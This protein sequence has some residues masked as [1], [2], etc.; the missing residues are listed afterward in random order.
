MNNDIA[1]I[2]N[3]GTEE[4]FFRP[5]GKGFLK[6]LG[7]LGGIYNGLSFGVGLG[8]NVI[9]ELIEDQTN[10][11][12]GNRFGADVIVGTIGFAG[13]EI[14]GDLS[15]GFIGPVG[16]LLVDLG[17]GLIYD[18]YVEK[19]NWV[20]NITYH[21]NKVDEGVFEGSAINGKPTYNIFSG[22]LVAE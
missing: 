5:T 6:S 2:L 16:G 17:S 15:S 19:N 3:Q 12:S 21:Y 7:R 13:P 22:H 14:I 9:P 10:A 11:A 20:G 18:S 1:K 4:I 8:L